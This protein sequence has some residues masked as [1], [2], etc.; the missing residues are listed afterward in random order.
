M[1][2]QL[3]STVI[4][5]FTNFSALLTSKQPLGTVLAGICAFVMAHAGNICGL[6]SWKNFR[7]TVW[8]SL[9]TKLRIRYK[10]FLYLCNMIDN[11]NCV[12]FYRHWPWIRY[13]PGEAKLQPC[14]SVIEKLAARQGFDHHN[15][16]CI[17]SLK[18][19][20]ASYYRTFW[21]DGT[22]RCQRILSLRFCS[23]S[24]SANGQR[25]GSA[26]PAAIL[27]HTRHNLHIRRHHSLR[28][29]RTSLNFV[30]LIPLL[31]QREFGCNKEQKACNPDLLR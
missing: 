28:R 8:T 7:N 18:M 10:I 25:F 30:T 21:L 14:S 16:W 12:I 23:N 19:S 13:S 24:C 6:A 11:L 9:C 29:R 2:A 15:P 20:A 17:R 1:C 22:N 27:R 3:L 26:S 31:L 5:E 4:A